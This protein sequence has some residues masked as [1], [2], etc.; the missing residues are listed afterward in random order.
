MYAAMCQGFLVNQH[1]G[2][3]CRIQQV[4]SKINLEGFYDLCVINLEG[5]Y[6]LCVIFQVME[7]SC[8]ELTNNI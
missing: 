3:C 4:F 2:S 8:T 6:D 1:V 5:F 7:L